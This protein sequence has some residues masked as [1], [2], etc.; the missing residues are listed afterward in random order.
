MPLPSTYSTSVLR[1]LATRGAALQCAGA[2]PPPSL[3]LTDQEIT[4][5]ASALRGEARRA[6][7][8]AADPQ[9]E[10]VRA[11]F[12]NSAEGYDYLA[13]KFTRIAARL[14]RRP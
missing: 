8:Q 11:I 4:Y 7:R 13:E 2:R 14:G 6:E 9:F 3:R 12:A 10:S 1:L 5:A